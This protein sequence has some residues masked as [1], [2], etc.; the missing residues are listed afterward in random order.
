MCSGVCVCVCVRARLC[1]HQP[2]VMTVTRRKRYNDDDD[3]LLA[4]HLAIVV[5][6]TAQSRMEE[7]HGVHTRISVR[8][9]VCTRRKRTYDISHTHTIC[10]P[11]LFLSL[12]LSLTHP[13]ARALTLAHADG[14]EGYFLR[15]CGFAKLRRER[16]RETK[17]GKR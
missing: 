15:G 10:A 4:S 16:E 6:P 1:M 11:S 17:R 5:Q 7:N 9:C 3:L 2:M 14:G 12:T 13:F 8:M